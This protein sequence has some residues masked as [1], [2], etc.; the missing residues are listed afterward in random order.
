MI[1]DNATWRKSSRSHQKTNCVEVALTPEAVGIRDTKDRSGGT[2][3]VHPRAWAGF[4]N[5]LKTGEYDRG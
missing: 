2:L 4:V 1:T 5:R 3:A